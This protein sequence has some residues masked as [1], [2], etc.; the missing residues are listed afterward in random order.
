MQQEIPA[1]HAEILVAGRGRRRAGARAMREVAERKG[2]TVLV[3]SGG[4]LLAG[5]DGVGSRPTLRQVQEVLDV[6]NAVAAELAGMGDSVLDALRDRLGCTIRL[7]GNQLTLDGDDDK[8]GE[9]REVVDELVELVEGGHQIG[10]RPSTRCSARSRRADD[11]R[12]VF[13]DVVWRHRG[14]KIAPKTVTQK[15][16]VDAIR[17]S[18]VTFGIGPAG[19]GKTYL[20]MALAVAALQE[21]AGRRGS[22]SRARRSRRASGSASCRATCSPRS[23]RTCGRSS[24]RSTTCSTP[25]A[26]TPTWSAARSRSRRSRS[27]AAAR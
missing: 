10:P 8:V 22:S 2:S 5:L 11:V 20:A 23:T 25:S 17:A 27:C 9:A 6:S 3:G 19:T 1:R 14:K 16:Y 18:T 7:R 26:R 15:R 4:R 12:E 13:E 24:T 21:R